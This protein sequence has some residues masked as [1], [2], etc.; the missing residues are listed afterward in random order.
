MWRSHLQ[1]SSAGRSAGHVCQQKKKT[2]PLKQKLCQKKSD[3]S[4]EEPDNNRFNIKLRRSSKT[5]R[6]NHTNKTTLWPIFATPLYFP[7]RLPLLSQN[8]NSLV[9][10]PTCDVVFLHIFPRCRNLFLPQ[11]YIYCTISI[12]ALSR[13]FHPKRL[14]VIH[15]DVH[16]LMMAAA[17]Q[18]ANQHIRSRLGF[19]ILP[20]DTSTCRPRESNQRPS[21]NKTLAPPLSDSRPQPLPLSLVLLSDPGGPLF[22]KEEFQFIMFQR[23]REYILWPKR[24]IFLSILRV[25]PVSVTIATLT[26]S[27]NSLKMNEWM[28][29]TEM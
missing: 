29:T 15:T 2:R 23:K 19:S 10:L 5:C 24:S 17:M 27:G 9:I 14:A 26:G 16:T 28:K 7:V 25:A 8:H 13:C 20:K 4:R 12:W 3:N 22:Q 21:D 18:G 6:R 1:L 11:Q